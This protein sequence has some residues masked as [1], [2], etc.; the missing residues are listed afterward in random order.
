MGKES[1]CLGPPGPVTHMFEVDVDLERFD[2]QVAEP[3]FV[4]QPGDTVVW[5]FRGLPKDWTPWISM[6]EAGPVGSVIEPFGPFA[7][8]SQ[9]ASTVLAVVRADLDTDQT[10]SYRAAVQRGLAVP[11]TVL[12]QLVSQPA[13][14]TVSKESPGCQWVFEVTLD[15][16]AGTL[17]VQPDQIV[18]KPGDTVLF[19][20]SHV[21]DEGDLLRPRVSFKHYTGGGTP[22][23]TFFGPFSSLVTTA[24]PRT[25]LG[26][27]NSMVAG[28][29]SF[30]VAMIAKA[31]GEVRWV[32]SVDP[33]VDNEGPPPDPLQ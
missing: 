3:D 14:V 9:A 32:A 16:D 30:E 20:F 29:Y 33:A 23:N 19:D 2:I 31:S 24:E 1:A 25:I 26:Q 7:S 22:P 8:I 12:A 6:D 5:Q 28:N 15:R 10:C 27:G 17:N 4:V 13:S 11:G 18:R 21:P